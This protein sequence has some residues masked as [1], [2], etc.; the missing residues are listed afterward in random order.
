MTLHVV[1][2]KTSLE[3]CLWNAILVG[4]LMHFNLQ[5]NVVAF[6]RTPFLPCS[7]DDRGVEFF[8]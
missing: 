8:Q 2:S 7:L 4:H 3:P 1:Q 6:L 5:F